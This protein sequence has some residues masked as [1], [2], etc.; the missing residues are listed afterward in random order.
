MSNTTDTEAHTERVAL[1]ID[2]DDEFAGDYEDPGSLTASAITGA[3]VYTVDWTVATVVNQIDADPTDPE[4]QGVL[5]T[6]PPFQRR[7]AW[8]DERQGLFIESLMLGLPI[9]PLVLAESMQHEGQFY[10]LD[11]K[12]RLTALKRFFDPADPLPLK[13][14]EILATELGGKTLAT[15]QASAELRKFSR[16]LASQPIR[17]IVVRNWRT[18]S[19]LHLIFSRLNKASVPLASHELRQALFPGPFTNFINEQSGL[20]RELQRAR[21]LS[22][23]D[24]RLRDAETLLRYLA[25]RTNISSYR[26][27]LRSFLDRVLKGGNDHFE[28]ARPEIEGLVQEMDAGITT[29]FEVFDSAAFLRFDGERNKYMPRFNVTVFDT[30]TWFFSDATV[31][32]AASK[33]AD[34]VRLAFEELSA[35]DPVFSAFLTSTTKT[36]D[37]TVGRLGRWGT[38]LGN[39]LDMDLD[40]RAFVSPVIPIASRAHG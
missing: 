24:F 34:G 30:L 33:N 20:S 36:N 3:V 31:R 23:P 28:D 9:P 26:G 21:R 19:L 27:D 39:I 7:T 13:G 4:S 25:F 16:T 17:T 8:T 14:L 18:P 2:S 35:S 15:I 12:Q 6:A 40:Y 32:D 1:E 37:A 10:V 11:G 29:T 22:A 5:V 38:A